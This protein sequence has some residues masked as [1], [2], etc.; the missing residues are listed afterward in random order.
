MGMLSSFLH[1][2]RAYDKAQKEMERYYGQGQEA[3]QPYMQQGQTAFAPLSGA[4]NALLNP[5]DLQN[6]WAQ[7]YE[8]SPYAQ[9]QMDMARNQG[10]EAASSMGIMGS[11]PALQS[12][13]AGQSMIGAADRDNYLNSLMQKYLAGAGVAQGIYGTGAGAASQFGQNAMNMGNNAAEM[14]YGKASAPGNMLGN[15][16]GLGV[17]TMFPGAYNAWNTMGGNRG[18]R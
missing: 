10:L 13:Q 3:L 1:P 17:G 11:S 6:E 8:T 15:L 12:I 4:M 18:M 16:I 7:S 14:A 2:G 9:M 5:I